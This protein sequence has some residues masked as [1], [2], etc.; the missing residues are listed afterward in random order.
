MVFPL[1]HNSFSTWV[2]VYPRFEIN[3]SQLVPWQENVLGFLRRTET[4]YD[5][6][7][8]LPAGEKWRLRLRILLSKVGGVVSHACGIQTLIDP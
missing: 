6:A 8:Q 2:L 1:T 4:R 7:W 3:K 5:F